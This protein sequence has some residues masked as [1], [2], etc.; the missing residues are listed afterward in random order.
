MGDVVSLNKFRKAKAKTA[1]KAAASE[2]RILHG[3]TKAD[4]KERTAVEQLDQTRYASHALDGEDKT[5][6]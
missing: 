3:E 6:D 4:R 1:K 5:E 2:N